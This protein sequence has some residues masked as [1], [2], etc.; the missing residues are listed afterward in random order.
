MSHPVQPH[1]AALAATLTNE[2]AG[3]DAWR[4]GIT[5]MQAAHE[6]VDAGEY[7]VASLE[8]A[9]AADAARHLAELAVQRGE[10]RLAGKFQLIAEL[11]DQWAT[12]ASD[13]ARVVMPV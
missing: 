2:P 10:H 4:D 13:A 7:R 6:H 8:Y 12:E 5:A 1:P 3:L 11:R 9:L